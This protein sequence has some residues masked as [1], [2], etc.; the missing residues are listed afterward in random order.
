MIVLERNISKPDL[1]HHLKLG[2]DSYYQDVQVNL[3]NSCCRYFIKNLTKKSHHKSSDIQ[4]AAVENF[5]KMSGDSY[6]KVTVIAIPL[7]KQNCNSSL[8]L[9]LYTSVLVEGSNSDSRLN[10]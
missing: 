4:I 1:G 3:Q 5:D 8:I 2:M 9:C 7:S 6:V 10:L